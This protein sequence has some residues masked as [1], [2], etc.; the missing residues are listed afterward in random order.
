V[1]SFRGLRSL[2][3]WREALPLDCPWTPLGARTLD[4]R[5]RVALSARRV[6]SPCRSL[7]KF[8]WAPMLKGK[9]ATKRM[10]QVIR[11]NVPCTQHVAMTSFD[12]I[13]SGRWRPT[14]RHL[15]APAPAICK[16]LPRS[17]CAPSATNDVHALDAA[18]QQT[19]S[20]K[21]RTN[22]YIPTI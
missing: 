13:T 16:L 5:Y 18:W 20:A 7:E 2:T 1:F 3:L 4:P 6:P 19:T 21:Y 14:K 11:R 12:D 9:G 8:L 22:L 10:H 17:V 15:A